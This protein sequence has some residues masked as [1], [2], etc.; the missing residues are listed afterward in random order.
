MRIPS[1]FCNLGN[2]EK[3][4]KLFL[5][6]VASLIHTLLQ[7]NDESDSPNNTPYAFYVQKT[8]RIGTDTWE[9]P[10]EITSSLTQYVSQQLKED[11]GS[12]TEQVL[13]IVFQ[14]LAIFRVRPGKLYLVI[15]SYFCICPT[16]YR[17]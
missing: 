3:L 16:I 8:K 15:L 11:G 13:T 7:S 9:E 12:I 17:F 4:I 2:L 1:R 5:I 14:P 10:T 6:F